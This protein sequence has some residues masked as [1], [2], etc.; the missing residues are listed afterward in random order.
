MNTREILNMA[1]YPRAGQ[2][3]RTKEFPLY[4]TQT[5]TAGTLEYF[6]LMKNES[7]NNKIKS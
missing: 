2:N 5:L 7:D 6:Y 1:L 4:D 3:I